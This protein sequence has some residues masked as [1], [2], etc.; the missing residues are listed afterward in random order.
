MGRP[1]AVRAGT[2]LRKRQEP[3]TFKTQIRNYLLEPLSDPKAV[4]KVGVSLP[5]AT[6]HGRAEMGQGKQLVADSK[7]EDQ[8][9]RCASLPSE[10][11]HTQGG[12]FLSSCSACSEDLKLPREQGLGKLSTTAEGGCTD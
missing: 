5:S 4:G 7:E 3:L 9:H 10:V 6:Q 1:R 8:Q 2:G 12:N 11:P